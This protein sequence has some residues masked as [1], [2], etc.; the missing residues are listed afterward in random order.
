ML[1]E[2]AARLSR[3]TA[4][5]AEAE[6]AAAKAAAEAEVARVKEH[7]RAWAKVRE[8][9]ARCSSVAGELDQ[10]RARIV[11]LEAQ[12]SSR[13]Q[14]RAA[15]HDE[16]ISL[17][18]RVK[19]LRAKVGTYQERSQ[20]RFYDV[21][22]MAEENQELRERLERREVEAR[23]QLNALRQ[24]MEEQR[25]LV[26]IFSSHRA[27]RRRKIQGVT[28]TLILNTPARDLFVCR[29]THRA[30]PRVVHVAGLGG[31]FESLSAGWCAAGFWDA[32]GRR[33]T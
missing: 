25:K 3:E 29:A 30:I 13:S 5:D 14:G 26:S 27:V 20:R 15:Q 32:H 6:A 7:G 9:E 33:L 23:Q 8:A 17:R 18:S 22:P 11:E 4:V 16:L 12:A 19:E 2:C 1:A 31:A 24:E 28:R 21:D 10:A